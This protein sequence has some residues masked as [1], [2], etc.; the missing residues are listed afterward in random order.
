VCG[1]LCELH[2]SL[3][4]Y[5]SVDL[6]FDWTFPSISAFHFNSNA[7]TQW[8]QVRRI[9]RAFPQLESL[10]ITSNLLTDISVDCGDT[11]GAA[12]GIVEVEESSG[13]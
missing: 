10:V 5:R 6:P 7:I 2:L 1:S 9:G 12:G 13:Q 11:E 8:S 4:E 3:N